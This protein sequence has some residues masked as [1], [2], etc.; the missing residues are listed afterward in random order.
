MNL[1]LVHCTYVEFDVG[2]G[3]AGINDPQGFSLR[4]Q[5]SQPL[6][7]KCTHPSILN[8]A[9]SCRGLSG[10]NSTSGLLPFPWDGKAPPP[11]L[12]ASS[13]AMEGGQ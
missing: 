12:L 10:T 8:D 9:G 4:A 1:S 11:L 3:D 2:T 5:S 7:I 13:P 6:I